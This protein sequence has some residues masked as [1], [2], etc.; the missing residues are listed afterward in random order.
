VIEPN[1][2]VSAPLGNVPMVTAFPTVTE[3]ICAVP[4]TNAGKELIVM[5]FPTVTAYGFGVLVNG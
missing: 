3:P 1:L 5:L 4:A 2:V